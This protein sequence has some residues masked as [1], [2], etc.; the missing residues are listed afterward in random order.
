M[1]GYKTLNFVVLLMLASSI[2]PTR[3]NWRPYCTVTTYNTG[4]VNWLW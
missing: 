3:C 4:Q 1:H 2:I